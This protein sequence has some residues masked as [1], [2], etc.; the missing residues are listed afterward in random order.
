MDRELRAAESS[1]A[2]SSRSD[3]S[4]YTNLP[5][6]DPPSTS[7]P[8]ALRP[9]QVF[10][11]FSNPGVSTN[12]GYPLPDDFDES[13]VFTV[14][15][16]TGSALGCDDSTNSMAMSSCCCPLRWNSLKIQAISEGLVSPNFPERK[17]HTM[18]ENRF[19]HFVVPPV[20][21]RNIVENNMATLACQVP[22]QHQPSGKSEC[23]TMIYMYILLTE[24]TE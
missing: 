21:K 13:P 3:Q 9:V 12:H 15:Q 4:N 14:D 22:V 8:D 1:T 20:S 5:A 10:E 19:R 18:Y 16:A 2:L 11:D 7:L 23:H 24:W 17:F 6:A